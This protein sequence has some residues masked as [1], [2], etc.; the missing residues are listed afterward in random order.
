MKH[1]TVK[2]LIA[3][4][5][6]ENPN[7][8]IAKTT[9]NFEQGHSTVPFTGFYKFKGKLVK[10]SFRDAFDGGSYDKEVIRHDEESGMDFL[11]F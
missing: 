7:A 9:D 8:I 2:D 10:E 4:L 5:Q 3:L 6:K 11:K 1:L